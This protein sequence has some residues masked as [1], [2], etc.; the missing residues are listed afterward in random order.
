MSSKMSIFVISQLSFFKPRAI[1]YLTSKSNG[2]ETTD[3]VNTTI[4][5]NP[6]NIIKYL[7]VIYFRKN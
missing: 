6:M 5:S 4:F 1:R 2:V 7:I 3:L